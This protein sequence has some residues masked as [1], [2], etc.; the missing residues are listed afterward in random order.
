MPAK[1]EA[2]ARPQATLSALFELG[3]PRLSTLV[4]FTAGLGVAVAPGPLAAW[5]V[6]VFLASTGLLVLAANTLNCVAEHE[7]DARMIRTRSRP[8][9][10]GRIP[11]GTAAAAG[12]VE[13]V[14]AVLGLLLSTQ[15][16]TALLGVAAF[17]SYVFAYTPLKRHSALALYVGG[18]PG[19]LPPL[20]GW[21]AVT[22]VPGA[23]GWTL[24]GLL[25][26]WQLPHFIAIAL[27]HRDDYS[28]GGLRVLTVAH[29]ERSARRQLVATTLLLLA[30]SLTPW[31]AGL[32]GALYVAVALAAGLAF[33]WHSLRALPIGAN[34][35]PAFRF[36]LLYLPIV[37][38]AL[39][40][41][42]HLP[43]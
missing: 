37:A 1:T 35:R 36:S 12:W 10:A 6:V 34:A 30:V 26:A 3:K 42:H 17:V 20:M 13:A 21:T 9:P 40:L 27:M 15:P 18:V 16:M 41:D 23:G 28:Q 43:W 24:F 11:A 7:I 14:V 31:W 4:L 33:L 8:I 32:G 22:G 38:G 19:A 29:G 2:A 5:R 25:F 39:I